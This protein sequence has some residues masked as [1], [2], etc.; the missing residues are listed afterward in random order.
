[1]LPTCFYELEEQRKPLIITQNGEAK[2]VLQ[3]VASYEDTQEMLAL[4]KIGSN[5]ARRSVLGLAV[6][7][8]TAQEVLP[9]PEEA[10]RDAKIG[11]T[12]KDSTPGTIRLTKAP[13]LT[14]EKPP[15]ESP[16]RQWLGDLAGSCDAAAL[17]HLLF[18]ISP[19]SER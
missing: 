13:E 16:R 5:A 11:R 6:S 9:K 4:L 19:R 3:D 18:N 7:V 14:A 8:A 12:Y 17:G 1:M 10:F 2:A 15:V